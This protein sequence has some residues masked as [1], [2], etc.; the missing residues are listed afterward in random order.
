MPIT[1]EPTRNRRAMTLLESLVA[2]SLLA[3]TLSVAAQFSVRHDRLL[4]DLR[5]YRVAVEELTDRLDHLVR[6]PPTERAAAI[7][8]LEEEGSPVTATA[9][10]DDLG[11]RVVVAY[12]WPA[13]H[14]S[15]PRLRL[16]GWAYDPPS[17]PNKE[18]P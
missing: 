16:S 3:V 17:A 9:E 6:L 2:L 7:A 13:P 1:R 5:A 12:E 10:P 18:A 14:A 15:R 11:V 8:A 4:T